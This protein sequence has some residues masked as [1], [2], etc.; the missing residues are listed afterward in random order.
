MMLDVKSIFSNLLQDA[1][2]EKNIN[3]DNVKTSLQPIIATDVIQTTPS[4][5]SGSSTSTSGSVLSMI[6]PDLRTNIE[7]SIRQL[8]SDVFRSKSMKK[9]DIN[10]TLQLA[11][12]IADLGYIDSYLIAQL[13]EDLFDSKSISESIEFFSLLESRADYFSQD[14]FMV[15]RT[16]NMLLKICIDLLKRLSKST[17]PD[18]CGRILIFLAF[19]FPLSD[20]SGLNPKSLHAVHGELDL[21]NIM[22]FEETSPEG[23]DKDKDKYKTTIDLNF[24]KQFW[25]L[26]SYFQKPFQLFNNANAVNTAALALNKDKW[27]H[28]MES[29]EVVL[30]TFATHIN[31][32]E[33]ATMSKSHYFTKYLTSSN[34]IKLQ[35]KDSTFRRNILTQLLITFQFIEFNTIKSP[36]LLNDSQKQLLTTLTNKAKKII[37]QTQPN[38]EHFMKSLALI[39]KRET[40]WLTWKMDGG[41]KAFGRPAAQSIVVKKRKLRKTSTKVMMGTQELSRL[42][43]LSSDNTES[44]KTEIKLN[45]MDYIAPMYDEMIQQEEAAKKEQERLARLKAK[46]TKKQE[47]RDAK[48]KK[49]EQKMQEDKKEDGEE[50]AAAEEEEDDDDNLDFDSDDLEDLDDPKPLLKDDQMY[51]WKTLRLI[52]RK[53]LEAFKQPSLNELIHSIKKQSAGTSSSSTSQTSG[54]SAKESSSSSPSTLSSS[55]PTT[56]TI[57]PPLQT[58]EKEKEKEKETTIQP[59][60][61]ITM[62]D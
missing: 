43:N 16:K 50:V 15:S 48:R 60:Q 7:L 5:Q 11:I 55:T 32:D 26:Q 47:E 36:N 54:S 57:V 58:N 8:F 37:E 31:L 53:R 6:A 39:L 27:S 22:D 52:S 45:V 21:T 17:N 24:Y 62:K 59:V 35:L 51:I 33:L 12:E 20:P 10:I 34:L 56:T 28:F 46:E 9:D 40:N 49:L 19:I 29:I 42:W 44:L 14:Q 61:D 3:I 1:L 18:S 13:A 4:T 23:K 38:G 2:N 41:C 25:G 30:T